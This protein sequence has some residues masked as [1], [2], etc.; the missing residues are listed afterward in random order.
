LLEAV[1]VAVHFQDVDVMGDGVEQSTLR[2][3]Q[4]K[5]AGDKHHA[6]IRELEGEFAGLTLAIAKMPDSDALFTALRQ[7]EAEL[8]ALKTTPATTPRLSELEIRSQVQ[9]ALSDLPSLLTK[10][11]AQA[12]A[13][14]AE[15]ISPVRLHPQPDGTFI[16]EGEWDLLGNRGPIMVAGGG[17]EPPTFGL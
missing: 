14:L 15:H 10:A 5:E 1:T 7:R 4:K 16:A 8:R 17:F 12:K 3:A 11:P 13:K 9:K 6:K 2:A